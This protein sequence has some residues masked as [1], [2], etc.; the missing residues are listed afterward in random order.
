MSIASYLSRV[1]PTDIELPA[2]VAT[3]V[4]IEVSGARDWSYTLRNIGA[5]PITAGDVQY[6]ALGPGDL[7]AAEAFPAGIPL[8]AGGVLPV[9]GQGRPIARLRLT[10]TS[11]AGTTVRVAGGG[12]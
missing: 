8:A 11:S 6:G 12:R 2:G 10:L 5:N 9:V 1:G 3:A 7:T 4:E